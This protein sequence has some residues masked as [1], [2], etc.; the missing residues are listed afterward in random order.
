[1]GLLS[2]IYRVAPCLYRLSQWC[3]P[4]GGLHQNR[5]SGAGYP[6]SLI[7]P[8]EPQRTSTRN[9]LEFV[10]FWGQA[11][12]KSAKRRTLVAYQVLHRTLGHPGAFE[13]RN[14][15]GAPAMERMPVTQYASFARASRFTASDTP[16]EYSP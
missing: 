4:R 11:R 9:R 1:M 16:P 7:H 14:H 15:R 10:V 2:S 3:R 5:L 6:G 13:H 8:L 12:A